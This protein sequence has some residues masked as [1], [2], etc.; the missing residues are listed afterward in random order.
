MV[1]D[2]HHW[3]CCR[4]M[5]DA[6]RQVVS[7][8][9]CPRLTLVLAEG[10]ISNQ[11]PTGRSFRWMSTGKLESDGKETNSNLIAMVSNFEGNGVSRCRYSINP[12]SVDTECAV[13]TSSYSAVTT[14]SAIL[15]PHAC[16]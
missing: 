9:T 12:R 11:S 5:K 2:A 14:S 13:T 4:G 15:K 3:N 7:K 6:C 1:V 16:D 8:E 10:L